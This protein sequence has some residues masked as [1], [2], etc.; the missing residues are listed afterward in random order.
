[1][2]HHGL[3]LTLH[4]LRLLLHHLRLVL[5]HPRLLTNRLHRTSVVARHL[6]LHHHRLLTGVHMCCIMIDGHNP[7]RRR[8]DCSYDGYLS[9]WDI[10]HSVA[11]DYD[12]W[13][14]DCFLININM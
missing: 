14:D 2:L 3:L 9:A 10:S 8:A 5:H 13:H 11:V 7:R 6:T 12:V 1:L 4:H